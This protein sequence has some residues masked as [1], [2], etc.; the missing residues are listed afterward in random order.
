MEGS[1]SGRRAAAG[2]L[3]R[4]ARFPARLDGPGELGGEKGGGWLRGPAL[5]RD[6][7]RIIGACRAEKA[8]TDMGDMVRVVVVMFGGNKERQDEGQQR[9]CAECAEGT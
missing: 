4:Q 6:I 9:S 7:K 5:R 3:V 8:G 2:Q 1:R